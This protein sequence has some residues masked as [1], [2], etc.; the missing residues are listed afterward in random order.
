MKDFLHE[1]F[2]FLLYG[3]YT[4]MI[5]DF[6]SLHPMRIDLST[7]QA[8]KDNALTSNR[9]CN[10]DISYFLFFIKYTSKAVNTIV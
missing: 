5:T 3:L 9:F 2:F 8:M 4:A 10:N 1:S 6:S 7:V